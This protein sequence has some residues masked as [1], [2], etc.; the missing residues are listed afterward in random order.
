MTPLA[1]MRFN[2]MFQY[3]LRGAAT[4]QLQAPMLKA[5]RSETMPMTFMRKRNGAPAVDD[6][7]NLTSAPAQSRRARSPREVLASL[8][9][10]DCAR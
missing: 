7:P 6:N 5:A 4:A 3:R 9:L 8:G 1:P 10:G 2:L